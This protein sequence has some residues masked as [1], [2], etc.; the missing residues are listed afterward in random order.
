M[1]LP[2]WFRCVERTLRS[3]PQEAGSLMFGFQILL[4]TAANQGS[5]PLETVA[6]D[7]GRLFLKVQPMHSGPQ[8]QVGPAQ[9]ES[10]FGIDDAMAR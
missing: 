7:L 5:Q 3:G 2:T 6:A 9:A 1:V 10:G 4:P 8:H